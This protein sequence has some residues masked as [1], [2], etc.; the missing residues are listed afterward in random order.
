[1]P[2][3]LRGQTLKNTFLPDNWFILEEMQPRRRT[4]LIGLADICQ[5]AVSTERVN[6]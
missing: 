5:I 2:Y 4:L 1:V 3:L 6:S